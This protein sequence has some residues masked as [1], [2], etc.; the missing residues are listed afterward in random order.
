MLIV[1]SRIPLYLESKGLRA[2]QALAWPEGPIEAEVF[3]GLREIKRLSSYLERQAY[4]AMSRCF[5]NATSTLVSNLLPLRAHLEMLGFT[6]F[7]K[8]G[9]LA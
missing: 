2:G 5:K 3:Q 6:R 1:F 8:S 7:K 4:G 9:S